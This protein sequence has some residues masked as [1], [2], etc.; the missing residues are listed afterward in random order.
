[1]EKI[2]ID[3][4]EFY[5][6]ATDISLDTAFVDLRY[7]LFDEAMTVDFVMKTFKVNVNTDNTWFQT[8]GEL[9]NA[10]ST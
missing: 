2:L 1:M 5:T 10:V 6:G 4:L 7:D 9:V 3:W 8:V